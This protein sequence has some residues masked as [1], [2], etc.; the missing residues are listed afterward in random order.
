MP[1]P[2]PSVALRVDLAQARAHWHRLQGLGAPVAGTLEE[3]VA[4]TGWPRTLGGVDVYL[5]LRAR[6]PGM[7][8]RALEEAVDA[9]RLQV[10]PAVRG[11]IY[12]VPAPQ[13]PLV[14]RVAEDQYRKRADREFERAG[15]AEKEIAGTGEA[16]LAALRQ[17][18]L[19]T[20]A[21][22][23][24]MPEGAV[25]SL[26]ERGKKVGLSSTLPPALRHLEFEGRVERALDGGRLDTER[27]LW[28]LPAKNPFAGAHV[29]GDA[30]ARHAEIA[31]IFLRSSGPASVKDFA[32][33]AA[34]SQR[35]AR[36]ALEAGPVVTVAVDGYADD[37]FLLE[38]QLPALREKNGRSGGARFS[39]LPFEDNYLVLHGGP[40]LLVD[41]RHHDRKI[42]VWGQS[43]GT[44]IGDAKHISLRAL[45]EG[46]A[47]TGLWE[48]DP[49]S[50]AV[51]FTTFDPLPP[52]RRKA[53]QALADDVGRFLGDEMG[54]AKSFTLDTTEA[55][56][57][58]ARQIKAAKTR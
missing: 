35:D 39:F 6:V 44:T 56:Q 54:H 22:R 28:R 32:E 50:A 5:A 1:R 53:L 36:A 13:V 58:R 21:L 10:I 18:A 42:P 17:G 2:A 52:A 26:G 33:W 47:V 3:V 51:V 37:A 34:L 45:V 24:A 40:R 7:T 43:R 8:R 16:V 25:R 49:G 27:Y 4:A 29:P 41:P 48:F 19:T 30:A 23:R 20:D 15:I 14:M 31:R 38:E 11:C 57:D 46:D 9:R 55:V 12:L